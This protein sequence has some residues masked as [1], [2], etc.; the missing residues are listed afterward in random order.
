MG[1]LCSAQ[2]FNANVE[3][4]QRLFWQQATQE[5]LSEGQTSLRLEAEYFRDWNQGDEQLIIEPFVRLD[6]VDDQRSHLDLRQFIWS[7][8]NDNSEFSIGVGQVFWGVT[9][10]QHLVDIINQTDS[11]EN[12]D[13]EDKLGQPMVR[14]S[15]F[16]DYGTFDAFLLPYFRARTFA[17]EDGRLNGGIL[18]DNHN[19]V[20]QSSSQET[21]LDFALRYAKTVGDLGIGLSWFSGTS[22][23]PD[24]FRFFNLTDMSTTPYY[25]LI[26]QFGLDLQLTT[27][28]WLFKLEAIQRN[29]NDSLSSDFAAATIGAEYS[30]VGVLGSAYDLGAL[31]EYSWDERRENASSLFQNDLFVGA[32]L[33]LNDMNDSEL[34][35]GVAQDLDVSSSRSIFIEAG[36]RINSKFSV[37]I[38]LRYFESNEPNDLLFRF[39]NDSFIQIG[40]EYYL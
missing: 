2:T 6:S 17:G 22:R 12:I 28:A 13:G 27:D 35:F 34:L 4:E 37:N 20:Y 15:Y 9:E 33:A 31:A 30:F 8:L 7:K 26:D 21:H 18:V 36:T 10:S 39:R 11:V 1:P 29:H 32:R 3:L 23:E 14:Y 24:L 40:L 16:N 25:A 19:E 38:E 5:N